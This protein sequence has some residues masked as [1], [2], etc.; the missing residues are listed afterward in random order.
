MRF[1]SGDFSGNYSQ[2]QELGDQNGAQ[3]VMSPSHIEY[4]NYQ[5]RCDVTI[6]H[7]IIPE[8]DPSFSLSGCMFSVVASSFIL[9]LCGIGMLMNPNQV[10]SQS[11]D[12]GVSYPKQ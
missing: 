8:P 11:I 9:F 12:N 4:S 10:P 1:G 3:G 2:T 5:P 7:Q 6:P